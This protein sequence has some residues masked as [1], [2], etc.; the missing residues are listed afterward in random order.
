[1]A[2]DQYLEDLL[3]ILPTAEAEGARKLLEASPGFSKE[4][5]EGY[6][7]QSDYSRKMNEF[8][9]DRNKF[10][11]EKKTMVD[12]YERNKSRHEQL[13]S[14]YSTAQSTINDLRS[15]IDRKV[16]SGEITQ[17]E[18]QS[19]AARV[20]ARLKEI[21]YTSKSELQQ[22]ITETAEKIADARV[23]AQTDRFLTETWPAATEIQGRVNEAQFMAMKEFGSPLSME[24]RKEVADLMKERNIMDPVKA[25][26]EWA[27][28]IRQKAEFDKKVEDEVSSRMSKQHFPGVSGPSIADMGPL[29]AARAGQV[30][31]LPDNAVV[32]DG[33][34]A[35]AAAAELRSEGR[36]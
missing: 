10:A 19:V 2:L 4:I 18:A 25:Y 31:K 36:F 15:Q 35:A 27:A 26:N 28:P 30:P 23:K 24:Q 1:M 8:D 16:E 3:K 5:K 13:M 29:Q 17:D 20:D 6:L 7:R 14:D 11:G 32:G 34:A 21:G 22:L 9:A 12:W 33:S